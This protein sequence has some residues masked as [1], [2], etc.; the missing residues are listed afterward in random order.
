MTWIQVRTDLWD[1]PRVAALCD[2]LGVCEATVVGGLFRLWSLADQHSVDGLLAAMT[3]AGLDRKTGLSGF[4][5]ALNDIDWLICDAD[6]LRVP[7]FH[8]HN[9]QSAKQRALAAKRMSRL[10]CGN[11]ALPLR[12]ERNENVTA[13]S[14]TGQDKDRPSPVSRHLSPE[15]LPQ[16]IREQISDDWFAKTAEP[17]K[18]DGADG[19][20]ASAF[21]P[22]SRDE[23]LSDPSAMADWWRYQLGR[24]DPLLGTEPAWCLVA[25]ALGLKFSNPKSTRWK[26]RIGAWANAIRRGWWNQAGPYLDRAEKLLR[27]VV[28]GEGAR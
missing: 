13:A 27:P 16:K 5:A 23:M 4:A 10:R 15:A 14:P 20:E 25:L 7:R 1:D 21:D 19:S 24:D 11:V 22:I 18:F 9:G 28:F 2:K 6:G 17:R 8:E 3:P 26:S 12:D